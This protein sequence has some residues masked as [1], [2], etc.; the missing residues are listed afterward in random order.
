MLIQDENGI[1][2][3]TVLIVTERERKLYL[4][5]GFMLSKRFLDKSDKLEPESTKK[6][7]VKWPK[8]TLIKGKSGFSEVTLA[9]KWEFWDKI[10]EKSLEV[11]VCFEVVVFVELR[12]STWFV[13]FLFD[14]QF[15]IKIGADGDKISELVTSAF[16]VLVAGLKDFDFVDLWCLQLHYFARH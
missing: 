1:M 7:D 12:F 15:G 3:F 11:W 13:K 14:V 16:T 8:E 9:I 5:K 6:I 2:E 4:M 10:W